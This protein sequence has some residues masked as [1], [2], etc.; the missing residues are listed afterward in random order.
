M[1][2]KKN[3][4]VEKVE[5]AIENKGGQDKKAKKTS[6]KKA[7]K[8]TRNK[9]TKKGAKAS[10]S[11]SAKESA[12]KKQKR[13]AERAERERIRAEKR[14]ELARIK[15]HKKAEKEKAKAT[16]LRER[17]RRKAEL[18]AR[19]EQIKADRKAKREMLKNETK[20]ERVK[21]IAEQKAAANEARREKRRQKI[22]IRKQK[23]ADKRAHKAQR[24]SNRQKNKDRNRG[25]GGWLAAV[26]SLGI[27]TLVLASVLTF[28]FLMPTETDSMLETT[29]RKSFFDAVEQVDNMDL[30]MSKALVTKDK[31]ALQTYLVDAAI[32]SE[33]AENDIQQLPLQD[34]SKYYTTKLVNQIGDYAKYLNNK[35]IQG[36]SL[37][38]QDYQG[39]RQLYEANK[40]FKESLQRT[41]SEMGDDF[42]LSSLLEGGNGN[43]VINNFNELQNLSVQYPELIYDGPFSDGQTDREIKGLS[44]SQVTEAEA[45]QIFNEIFAE[46][47]LEDVKNVGMVTS[48]IECYNVQ[49]EKD[50]D[51][52]FAQI[53][54][55]GGKMIMFSYSGSCRQVKFGEDKAIE[56]AEKFLEGL[57][58]SGMKPVWINLSN[59]LYT[60]NFAYAKNDV[61]IYSDLIKIRVCAETGK[62]IGFEAR[63][64]YTNHTD[65]VIESPVL[66]KSEA[67]QKVSENIEIES[68]RLSLV[69]VGTKTEKLCYEFSGECEGS[70]FYVYID[71]LTG[72]QVEMFKVIESTEGT[73]LM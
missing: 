48:E 35:I 55:L 34:E 22:E 71:A 26:I 15:A 31:G 54:K 58:I 3:N 37:S 49:G 6:E 69:P 66:S 23:L 50:G 59:N 19:R 33:L 57:K 13:E 20:K 4:A 2:E 41:V 64:Y 60:I 43:I 17:N 21:R 29:Y 16:A 52:L 10:K 39:L 14:V 12:I 40:T 7:K 56:N 5:N 38:E 70:V 45:R 73:L 11:K 27:A 28:T 51:I 9:L 36:E 44:G 42:N 18:K 30:N 46:Y 25:Y 61:I 8:S 24:S 62:V 47:S 72:R 1:E 65:R 63:A 53:S 68:A 32:N 67:Q